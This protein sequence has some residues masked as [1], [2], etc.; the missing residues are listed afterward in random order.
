MVE[1]RKQVCCFQWFRFAD[2]SQEPGDISDQRF[3]TG[4]LLA[5]EA[6]IRRLV[7]FG[8][9]DAVFRDQ[10]RKVQV[11][12]NLEAQYPEQI[13]LRRGRAQQIAAPDDLGHPHQPIVCSDGQL[14]GKNPVA[15]AD[16][17]VAPVMG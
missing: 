1:Q 12:R 7:P 3:R 8:Q 17:D 14:V 13:N 2:L 11:L 9:A 5:E 10:H 15:A 16:D 6:H 4:K